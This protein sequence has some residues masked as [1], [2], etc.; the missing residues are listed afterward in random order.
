MSR[1]RESRLA[2]TVSLAITLILGWVVISAVVWRQTADA[3]TPPRPDTPPPGQME[4]M[5]APEAAE[6]LHDPVVL[7]PPPAPDV[8]PVQVAA[9]MQDPPKE[10][11]APPENPVAEKTASVAPVQVSAAP[12]KPLPVEQSAMEKIDPVTPDREMVREGR[13]LLKLLERGEGPD[14]EIAWPGNPSARSRLYREFSSCFGM[15]TVVVGPDRS[16]YTEDMPPGRP[17]MPDPD[18]VSG[19]ARQPR[20]ALPAAERTHV[21]TIRSRHGLSGGTVIRVFPRDVDAGFLGALEAVATDAYRAGATFR[22]SYELAPDGVRITGIWVD[23]RT[24][25]QPVLLAGAC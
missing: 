19:Y 14:I 8:A 1:R 24:I 15:R 16:L 10:P 21:D 11:E 17:W 2:A 5:P 20:G 25:G 3:E 4:E 9:P 22:A 7:P 12:L 23:G 6:H 18:G 13:V